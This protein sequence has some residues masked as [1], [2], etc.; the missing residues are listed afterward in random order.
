MQA[1]VKEIYGVL[2]FPPTNDKMQA[3]GFTALFSEFGVKKVVYGH[4]HSKEV[5]PRGLQGV[6]N[7]VE[8]MLCSLDY[9]SCMPRKLK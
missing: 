4:L 2:H 1:G 5:Y 8:Y 7:G 9:L 6:F 3:S